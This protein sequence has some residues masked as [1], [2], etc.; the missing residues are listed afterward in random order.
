MTVNVTSKSDTEDSYTLDNGYTLKRE[1]D[2]LTPNGNRLNGRWAL[3]NSQGELVD[4]DKYRNDLA[5]RQGIS[6]C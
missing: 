6:L 4:F 1:F 5:S 2:T 3:R